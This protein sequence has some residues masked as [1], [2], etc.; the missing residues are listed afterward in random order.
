M[1]R[2]LIGALAMLTAGVVLAQSSD[3]TIRQVRDPVQQ[4]AKLN[5]DG[6]AVEVRLAA[7]EAGG[8]GATITAATLISNATMKVYGLAGQYL[9]NV[10]A[11]SL[12][13][14]GA[15]GIAEGMLTDSTV[16][17]ADIKDGEVASADVLNGSLLG[18]DIRT[19][20]VG[21]ANLAAAD[22]G[23]FTV[24]ADG[25]CEIDADAVGAAEL[26]DD[27]V[28]KASLSAVDYGDFTA[29]SDGTCTLDDGVVS[30][31]KLA[32]SNM[33]V[34]TVAA[35]GSMSFTTSGWTGSLTNLIWNAGGATGTLTVVD[36]RI[37]NCTIP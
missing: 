1:K 10:T 11:A 34:I 6:A 25:T 35:G 36:G 30:S 20:T 31:N 27:A 17:G 9:G 15:V 7:V 5:V 26:A 12:T 18:A 3:W 8:V 33:G 32:A 14:T 16:V 29:G 2:I 24:G 21:K 23:D 19:N 13:A 37:T 22:F 4:A 28:V